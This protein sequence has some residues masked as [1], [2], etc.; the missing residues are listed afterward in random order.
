MKIIIKCGDVR[1]L[2]EKVEKFFWENILPMLNSEIMIESTVNPVYIYK[3][4]DENL[5]ATVNHA[6]E[7]VSSLDAQ[8]VTMILAKSFSDEEIKSAS[9]N[10]WD[11]ALAIKKIEEL[12]PFFSREYHFY[13]YS[14]GKKEDGE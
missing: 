9:G 2:P 13:L 12:N 4:G 8:V 10:L 14:E 7:I 5:K 3:K 11:E 1:F 6:V